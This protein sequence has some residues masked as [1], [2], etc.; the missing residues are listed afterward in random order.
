MAQNS[1][2]KNDLDGKNKEA[3][4]VNPSHTGVRSGNPQLDPDAARRDAGKKT[5]DRPQSP[6]ARGGG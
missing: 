1:D 5:N 2:A 6:P 4:H 3:E